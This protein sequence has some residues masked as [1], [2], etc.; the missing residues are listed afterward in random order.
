MAFPDFHEY[1]GDREILGQNETVD[2]L[3]KDYIA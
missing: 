3:Y 2:N 1:S